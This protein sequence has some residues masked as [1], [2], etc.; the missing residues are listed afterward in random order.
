[1]NNL[2]ADLGRSKSAN[3]IVQSAE[4][5]N[6]GFARV[7]AT[8]AHV[9]GSRGTKASLMDALRAKFDN[10]LFPV[11]NS[12]SVLSSNPVSDTV[13]G[14]LSVAPQAVSYTEDLQG[15][16]ILAGNMFM[17]EEENLWA[18]RKTEAGDI[19]VK[20]FGKDDAEVVSGLLNSVSS[21]YSGAYES[22]ASVQ[23]TNN[24]LNSICGG[25][26]VTY[27]EPHSSKVSFGA[28]VASVDNAD[29]TDSGKLYVA[30]IDCGPAQFVDRRMVLA[31][32]DGVE[33]EDD[34]DANS[35]VAT[36]S[37]NAKSPEEIAAYY[38]KVFQRNDGYFQKFM[39]RWKSH[40]FM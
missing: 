28:V 35:E 31:S 12:F 2:V 21:S 26:Y 4:E 17:D 40:S 22:V 36:S 30:D 33:V 37:A 24:M 18:L 14:I 15:F 20:S 1:M 7:I 13:T 27:V 8:V 19:L 23:N 11:E 16:K 9:N 29:G 3:V 34:V 25:D 32:W 39:E 10:K 5:L 38:Q 6:D